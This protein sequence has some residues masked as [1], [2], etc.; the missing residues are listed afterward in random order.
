MTTPPDKDVA[1]RE[2]TAWPVSLAVDGRDRLLLS[3]MAVLQTMPGPEGERRTTLQMLAAHAAWLLGGRVVY[4]LAPALAAAF[5]E[6]GYPLTLGDVALPHAA[7]FIHAPGCG[8]V[9][10]NGNRALPVNGWYVSRAGGLLDIVAVSDVGSMAM[11]HVPMPMDVE[12]ES[13]LAG[14]SER[15][16]S[17]VGADN[18]GQLVPWMR[19]VAGLCAYLAG[20]DPDLLGVNYFR[21]G[22]RVKTE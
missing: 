15:N 12:I 9:V 21:V 8:L 10:S 17:F 7:F 6:T 20:D 19:V 3:N 18:T 14:R 1:G 13:W 5:A 4:E 2:V 11:C 22:T 16:V